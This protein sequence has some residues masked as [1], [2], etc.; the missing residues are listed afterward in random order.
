MLQSDDLAEAVGSSQD[1]PDCKSHIPAQ[2]FVPA[3]GMKYA[4]GDCCVAV[5]DVI[6]DGIPGAS[7]P[8]FRVLIVQLLEVAQDLLIEGVFGK[9]LG[10]QGGELFVSG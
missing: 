3:R 6:D 8:V 2:Q 1:N 4:L 9:A 10:V 7:V 5:E